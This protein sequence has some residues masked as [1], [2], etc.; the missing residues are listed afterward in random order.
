GLTIDA[1]LRLSV[2]RGWFLP[3]VPGTKFVTLGGA[4]ANDIHGKNHETAGTIGCHVIRIGVALSSGEVVELSTE[5]NP[6]LFAAS[7]G[8]LGLTGLILWVE[9][10]LK[11]IRSA[12]IEVE[13]VR[14][15]DLD[16]FFRLSADSGQ[17][18]YTV[19][20]V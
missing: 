4:V 16:D 8:G 6:D 14:M 18:E 15:R 11:S 7:V 2:P 5:Q 9:I 17:W 3:V 10:G 12:Y 19:A 1:L 13:T 20:W